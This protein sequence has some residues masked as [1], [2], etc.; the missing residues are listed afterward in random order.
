MPVTP[1]RKGFGQRYLTA[2]WV[3]RGETLAAI[4]GGRRT[5]LLAPWLL[6]PIKRFRFRN[7]SSTFYMAVASRK[8]S[9]YRWRWLWMR[10]RIETNWYLIQ[11]T[12]EFFGCP[13]KLHCAAI[14]EEVAFEMLSGSRQ[15][16]HYHRIRHSG[17]LS[18]CA[19]SPV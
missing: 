14:Y 9:R 16:R 18:S 1:G 4:A 10:D 19:G 5:L 12:S 8:S 3:S 13:N 2:T 7:V 15:L 17:G 6:W 11:G